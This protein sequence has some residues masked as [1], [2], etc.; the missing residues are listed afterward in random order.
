MAIVLI[1]FNAFMCVLQALILETVPNW[2]ALTVLPV[3]M[4][5]TQ[6]W[7]KSIY[8]KGLIRYAS[9]ENIEKKH[10]LSLQLE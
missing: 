10:H 9:E 1:A 4:S 7:K 2:S 3:L 5:A 6:L 8:P